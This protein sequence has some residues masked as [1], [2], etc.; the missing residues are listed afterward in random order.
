MDL[1]LPVLHIGKIKLREI[2]KSDFPALFEVGS[3]PEMCK[4]LNWG[5]YKRVSEALYAIEGIY[6]KRHEESLPIP[7]AI[8][9]N[10]IL[11]GVLE[12]HSYNE[13]E[14]SMEIGFFLSQDYWGKG[15]MTKVLKEAIMLGFY[16]L[17]LKKIVISTLAENERCIK[18]IKRFGLEYQESKLFEVAEE[19][20]E[21]GYCYSIYKDD[22]IWRNKLL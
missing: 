13:D 6:L 5:P 11:I 19:R 8:C 14:K 1:S 16:Q 21:V 22:Y 12:Y 7:Y 15:I 4:Y 20:F 10:D 2:Q 18:L 9:I 3:N 17:E